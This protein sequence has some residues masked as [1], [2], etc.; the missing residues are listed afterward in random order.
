[1]SLSNVQKQFPAP[2][3]AQTTCPCTNPY[4]I[5]RTD[6]RPPTPGPELAARVCVCSTGATSHHGPK[7][8]CLP[9]RD[10]GRRPWTLPASSPV[11]FPRP[12]FQP[13]FGLAPK[14]RMNALCGTC[15]RTVLEPP[16][17]LLLPGLRAGFP[18]TGHRGATRTTIQGEETQVQGS[19]RNFH[20]RDLSPG[21]LLPWCCVPSSECR[22]ATR[23]RA[24]IVEPRYRV[25][26][27]SLSSLTGSS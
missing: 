16:S 12:G 8:T 25:C 27:S 13:R 20:V 14:R 6:P 21:T 26:D 11:S 4:S 7:P 15:R 5:P 3:D 10:R 18:G 24:R 17:I 23:V 19:R 9:C 1:M 22:P 2:N